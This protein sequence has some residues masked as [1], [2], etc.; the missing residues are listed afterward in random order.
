MTDLVPLDFAGDVKEHL[1]R[2]GDG[3]NK[4]LDG[5]NRTVSK[6]TLTANTTTTTVTSPY[7]TAD[8]HISLTP[9][10]ANA[11]GVVASTYISARTSGASFTITHPSDA[12]TDK[13][14]TYEISN[15]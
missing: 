9:T 6:V 4:A 3:A 10:T 12:D 13:T 1:R 8:S 7:V 14:F 5:A 15:P 2:V 11:A